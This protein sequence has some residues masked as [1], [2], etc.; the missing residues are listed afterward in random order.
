[1]PWYF[2]RKSK[3]AFCQTRIRLT[4][5]TFFTLARQE[6]SFNSQQFLAVLRSAWGSILVDFLFHEVHYSTAFC[7]GQ[8]LFAAYSTDSLLPRFLESTFYF[9][10]RC[11]SWFST[12]FFPNFTLKALSAPVCWFISR[13]FNSQLMD[14]SPEAVSPV[15]PEVMQYAEVLVRFALRRAATWAWEASVCWIRHGSPCL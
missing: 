9:P 11:S 1:M 10:V 5:L 7:N 14:P 3:N 2:T 4:C 8:F 6:E 12:F 13:H 15:P